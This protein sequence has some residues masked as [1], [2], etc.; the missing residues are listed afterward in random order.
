MNFFVEAEIAAM[1]VIPQDRSPPVLSANLFVA[2]FIGEPPMPT[3]TRN[4]TR[5]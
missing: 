2:K 1:A 3:R 4:S 5:S